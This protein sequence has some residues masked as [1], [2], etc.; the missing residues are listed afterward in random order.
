[1]C[2]NLGDWNLYRDVFVS[3]T[4]HLV[5]FFSLLEAQPLSQ[6]GEVLKQFTVQHV[7]LSS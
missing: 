4:L 7:C 6:Y 3:F 1:M 2:C 5:D